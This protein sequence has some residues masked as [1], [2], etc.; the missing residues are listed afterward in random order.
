[1]TT[2]SALEGANACR[3]SYVILVVLSASTLA[4]CARDGTGP[5]SDADVT[6]T[7]ICGAPGTY[8][9]DDN[10]LADCGGGIANLYG[11]DQF[12]AKAGK[13]SYGCGEADLPDSD[14]TV[15]CFCRRDPPDG[16]VAEQGGDPWI[17]A[18]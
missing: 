13:Y 10:T 15:A 18:D 17:A 9:Y 6:G 4:V 7:A 3:A 11:C 1:M 16:G 5:V 12:C 2:S 14:W 8:C